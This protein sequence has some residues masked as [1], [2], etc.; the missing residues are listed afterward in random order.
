MNTP[1]DI[2]SRVRKILSACDLTLY[3][4]SRHSADIFGRHSPYYVP[5]DFYCSLAARHAG[6][7]IHQFVSLSRISK[8]RLCD[9]LR[10]FS[11]P[12]DD[13]LRLRTLLPRRRSVLLDS[14]V[15][16]ENQWV[17]SSEERAAS[18]ARSA[19]TP[20]A[21]ILK[22]FHPTRAAKWLKLN[23]GR[24]LY[25][26]IGREDAF[27]FPDLASGSIARI[28][29]RNATQLGR[30]LRHAP[31]K[32]VFAVET[33]SGLMCGHLRRTNG[34]QIAL[35]STS[36]SCPQLEL[37]LGRAAKILGVV[38]AEIRPMALG[39]S[40][41]GPENGR[42]RRAIHTRTL[43]DCPAGLGQFIQASRLRVGASFRE[44][45]AMSCATAKILSDT[46]YF[47]S[48][49]TLSDYE[50]LSAPPRHV[51]KIL[52][53][54]IL[55]CIGFWDFLR[56][57]EVVL[58]S[59]GCDPMPDEL[60]GR[61]GAYR[62]EETR[63]RQG[64]VYPVTSGFLSA[65]VAEW[66][67]VP[68]F[69]YRSLPEIIGISHP[70]LLDF[71]WIGAAQTSSDPRMENAILLAVN[72]RLKKSQNLSS[73]AP[74]EQPVYLMIKRDGGYICGACPSNRSDAEVIGQVAAI[75][76]RLP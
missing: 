49:G 16:D 38:D 64:P 56:A 24:F 54:C 36:F 2:A 9:W 33:E 19:I 8:Y 53:L 43:R 73:T 1:I 4:V 67:E 42:T 40:A 32:R 51:Q 10:V 18:S 28:D 31:S 70:S 68:L 76:R 55:Y 62:R 66:Q 7:S 44:S 15:Y 13:I 29:I 39:R 72:R 12:L 63:P 35:C 30:E 75:L 58:D 3:Q 48:P 17:P 11:F 41:H 22:P 20:L 61:T 34:S 74:R 14:S 6:P 47:A 57:G 46:N 52:S 45:S 59:I 23:S 21:Q 27:A 60:C 50:H 25:A 26:K 37:T 69:L 65:I 71:F 5:Q